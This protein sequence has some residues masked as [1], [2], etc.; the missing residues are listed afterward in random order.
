MNNLTLSQ[1][2]QVVIKQAFGTVYHAEGSQGDYPWRQQGLN[3]SRLSALWQHIQG[4]TNVKKL[5]QQRGQTKV[6]CEIRVSE[7]SF[8]PHK[9]S[10][11]VMRGGTP[12]VC[13]THC[14]KFVIGITCKL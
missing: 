1:S 10:D 6:T 14:K 12:L 5:V 3:T 4:L 13:P 7:G 8:T 9:N 11:D 2:Q